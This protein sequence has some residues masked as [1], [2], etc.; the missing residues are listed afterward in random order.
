MENTHYVRCE[1][2]GE[3]FQHEYQLENHIRRRHKTQIKCDTCGKI[4]RSEGA[5]EIHKESH[6][7]PE[8][9]CDR[10]FCTAEFFTETEL[11]THTFE[12]E[13]K[14]N[15]SQKFTLKF[16]PKIYSKI[17]EKKEQ[18][19]KE[20]LERESTYECKKCDRKFRTEKS[21][22]MHMQEHSDA[23]DNRKECPKCFRMFM[24]DDS[25]TVH[26]ESAHPDF[27]YNGY[28]LKVSKDKVNYRTSHIRIFKTK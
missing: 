10:K 6:K 3:T 14:G 5:L 16:S 23:D 27:D 17:S 7:K 25:L 13:E 28:L 4:F 8:F 24:T 1:T 20:Q 26:I 11:L 18:M 12:H 21:Y 22:K 2:C 15:F 9:K 19:E